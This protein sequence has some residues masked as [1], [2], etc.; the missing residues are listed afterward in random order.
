MKGRNIRTIE[1]LTGV[2]LIIDETPNAVVVSS[3][4][5]VRGRSPG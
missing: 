1:S 3:F 4:D 5:G 2:D